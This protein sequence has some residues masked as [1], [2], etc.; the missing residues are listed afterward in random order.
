MISLEVFIHYLMYIQCV[1]SSDANFF[2]GPDIAS[3]CIN[4]TYYIFLKITVLAPFAPHK[5]LKSICY[6][7]LGEIC[8][9]P[10]AIK[11]MPFHEN[12][13]TSRLNALY[14]FD[15]SSKQIFPVFL[16]TSYVALL[17]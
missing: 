1:Q 15:F 2:A 5:L 16:K 14:I 9:Y 13:R 3:R 8:Q 7:F 6:R 17:S 10:V 12:N 11:I 4:C